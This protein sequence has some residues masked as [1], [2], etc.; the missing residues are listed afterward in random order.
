[1]DLRPFITGVNALKRQHPVL[2]GEGVLRV[3]G[4][5]HGDTLLLERRASDAPLAERGWIAINKVWAEGRRLAL[6]DLAPEASGESFAAYRVCRDGGVDE[7]EPVAGS[8]ELDRA[9]VVYLLPV[10]ARPLPA[11]PIIAEERH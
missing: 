3:C 5:L 2:Q 6:R 9:E 8:L 1:M 7:P 11:R 10:A 4:D